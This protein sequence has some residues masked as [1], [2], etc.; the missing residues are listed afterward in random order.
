M[1]TH[2]ESG[3]CESGIDLDDLNYRAVQFTDA[4]EFIDRDSIYSYDESDHLLEHIRRDLVVK[5]NGTA[6]LFICL[7]CEASFPKLS[8]LFQHIG[9]ESCEQKLDEGVIEE[10][11][12]Y[13]KGTFDTYG[14][15]H[16][17]L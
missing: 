6:F 3:T 10:L 8:S 12:T 13:L 1:I 4:E 9:T 16:I 17:I 14:G 7:T 15:Y 5:D 2:L 11:V